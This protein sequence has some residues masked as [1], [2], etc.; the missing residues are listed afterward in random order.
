MEDEP[1]LTKTINTP[2]LYA[3]VLFLS[4]NNYLCIEE[5]FYTS[6]VRCLAD[7]AE[8]TVWNRMETPPTDGK[9]LIGTLPAKIIS[10]MITANN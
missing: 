8:S 1:W 2:E 10:T 5:V 3:R 6:E 7:M 9:E 4:A